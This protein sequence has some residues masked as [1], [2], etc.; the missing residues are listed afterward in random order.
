M[1][2]YAVR[3]EKNVYEEY[4]QSPWERVLDRPALRTV[5]AAGK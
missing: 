5:G 4:S 3:F 1:R 2:K